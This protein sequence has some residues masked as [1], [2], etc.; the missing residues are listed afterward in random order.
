MFNIVHDNYDEFWQQNIGQSYEMFDCVYEAL[1]P[2]EH[3]IS[4]VYLFQ[5]D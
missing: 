4:L 3:E 5:Q 2:V 1:T